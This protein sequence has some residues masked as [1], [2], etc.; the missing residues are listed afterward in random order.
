MASTEWAPK[1]YVPS[2]SVPKPYVPKP[3]NKTSVQP[4]VP[5]KGQATPQERKHLTDF[6][7]LLLGDFLYGTKE[8]QMQLRDSGYEQW[9]F[10]PIMNRIVGA[11]AMLKERQIEPMLKG[12]PMQV[13][14]NTLETYSGTM[15][16]LS[17]PIKSLIP[18]AGGGHSGDFLRS[19]GWKDGEFRK[20]FQFNTGNFIVDMAGEILTDP[21]TYVTA[22]GSSLSKKGAGV[23]AEEGID[24]VRKTLTKELGAE[25]TEQVLS[26]IS[27]NALNALI[28]EYGIDIIKDPDKFLDAM[29]AFLQSRSDEITRL[30]QTAQGNA[31]DTLLKKHGAELENLIK[32]K[33]LLSSTAVK[34]KIAELRFSDGYRYYQMA[35]KLK[36]ADKPLKMAAGILAPTGPITVAF[37]KYI[38]RPLFKHM[39]FNA[40]N[41]LKSFDI[42][43]IMNNPNFV[44]NTITDDVITKYASIGNKFTD[45]VIN[46]NKA[47]SKLYGIITEANI[48]RPGDFEYILD[49]FYKYLSSEFRGINGFD[50]LVDTLMQDELLFLVES[51]KISA[52]I[53]DVFNKVKGIKIAEFAQNPLEIVVLQQS[54]K[55]VVYN[56][57]KQLIQDDF[58]KWRLNEG[59][60]KQMK[61]LE[62]YIQAGELPKEV[63]I[64]SV[65]PLD[66]VLYV[67]DRMFK[68][69]LTKDRFAELMKNEESVRLLNWAG[70][71]DENIVP[72]Q[73][74][75][76]NYFKAETKQAKAKI[77]KEI[78][79]L[80]R[81]AKM[82]YFGTIPKQ[83][84]KSADDV[85]YNPRFQ[86]KN[87]ESALVKLM[88]PGWSAAEGANIRKGIAEATSPDKAKVEKWRFKKVSKAVKEVQDV[89]KQ[90]VEM[91]NSY[92]FEG[93][94]NPVEQLKK[95]NSFTMKHGGNYALDFKDGELVEHVFQSDFFSYLDKL[96]EEIDKILDERLAAG[97]AAVDNLD[98]ARAIIRKEVYTEN[99]DTITGHISEFHKAYSELSYRARSWMAAIKHGNI[100][101]NSILGTDPNVRN[102]ITTL[103]DFMNTAHSAE[104]LDALDEIFTARQTAQAMKLSMTQHF[105]LANSSLALMDDK[106]LEEWFNPDSTMRKSVELIRRQALNNPNEEVRMF[107]MQLS[108]ILAATDS[109]GNFGKLKEY[110][111]EYI[112]SL[113]LNAEA[114]AFLTNLVDDKMIMFSN[115]G[116]YANMFRY[117]GETPTD[118]YMAQVRTLISNRENFRGA[119][120]AVLDGA[121]PRG[122]YTHTIRAMLAQHDEKWL[123]EF[124]KSLDGAKDFLLD[125]STFTYQELMDEL[126]FNIDKLYRTYMKKQRSIVETYGIYN[127]P[128][129]QWIDGNVEKALTELGL[130]FPGVF[131]NLATMNNDV[132]VM[133][134]FVDAMR[135]LVRTDVR[136]FQNTIYNLVTSGDLKVAENASETFLVQEL[137]AAKERGYNVDAVDISSLTRVSTT[138]TDAINNTNYQIGTINN[139]L[140]GTGTKMAKVNVKSDFSDGFQKTIKNVQNYLLVTQA[141]DVIR[142]G[143]IFTNSYEWSV[144][145]GTISFFDVDDFDFIREHKLDIDSLNASKFIG[146]DIN[147]NVRQTADSEYYKFIS[148]FTQAYENQSH[149]LVK[150]LEEVPTDNEWYN[151]LRSM[152]VEVY[153]SPLYGSVAYAPLDPKTYFMNLT[154]RE[155]LAWN[156]I[157]LSHGLHPKM[158]SAYSEMYSE[159]K[160]HLADVKLEKQSTYLTEVQAKVHKTLGILDTSAELQTHLD[161]FGS[162][163]MYYI[164]QAVEEANE[165]MLNTIH[166][167]NLQSMSYMFTN[168]YLARRNSNV[169]TNYMRKDIT[170]ARHVSGIV[171]I[172]NDTR[173]IGELNLTNE[174][175][176]QLSWYGITKDTRLN[177]RIVHNYLQLERAMDVIYSIESWTPEQLATWVQMNDGLFI[178]NFIPTKESSFY[179]KWI[180]QVDELEKLGITMIEF[181]NEAGAKTTNQYLF[182]KTGNQTHNAQITWTRRK[183][184]LPELQDKIT[185]AF[186]NNADIFEDSR[187]PFELWDGNTITNEEFQVIRDALADFEAE[188]YLVTPKGLIRSPYQD[189][190][191]NLERTYLKDGVPRQLSMVLGAQGAYNEL[192]NHP[193]VMRYYDTLHLEAIPKSTSLVKSAI[194]GSYSA[195]NGRNDVNKYLSFFFPRSEFQLDGEFWSEILKDKSD[196]DI[197]KMFGHNQYEAVLLKED[198]KGLPRVYKI[199]ID[200]KRDLEKAIKAG[201]IAVPHDVYRNMVLVVNKRKSDNGFISAW[202]HIVMP[203][204]KTIAI[205]TP[206]MA[207]RNGIDSNIV[208]NAM[209]TDG[210]KGIMKNFEYEYKAAK[211][212]RWYEELY[213]GLVQAAQAR[214]DEIPSFEDVQNLFN[215]LGPG[216][217]TLFQNLSLY[218]NSGASSGLTAPL[219]DA[220]LRKHM[221]EAADEIN[222]ALV[223]Y[224]AII[225]GNPYVKFISGINGFFE[226]TAR[227]GLYLRLVDEGDS[228][229]MALNKVID[230]HFDYG[231]KILGSDAIERLFWFSTFPIN[232][233]A[234]FMNRWMTQDPLLFKVQLNALKLSWN[235]GEN[236]TWD[237]VRNSDYLTYNVGAGNIRFKFNGKDVLLKTGSS[238]LDFLN[239]I[240]DPIGS[241]IERLNPLMTPF[242]KPEELE[243]I[244]PLATPLARLEQIKS[245]RSYIPSLY[246]ILQDFNRPKRHYIEKAPYTYTRSWYGYP[247]KYYPKSYPATPS[248][249][250]Q[251]RKF[252]TRT[253]RYR[254][255]EYM[256]YFGANNHKDSPLFHLDYSK[257]TSYIPRYL[258]YRKSAKN[259]TTQRVTAMVTNQVKRKAI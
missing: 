210:F 96:D 137:R 46:T 77:V 35:S 95:L 50:P 34:N 219:A 114:T 250:K 39:W 143:K 242:I 93:D 116:A 44:L 190:L 146:F 188:G 122:K 170:H 206:G 79:D 152:L 189:T 70:I 12:K 255:W 18:A 139:Y 52:D 207:I 251:L 177:E 175:M 228:I 98:K 30:I 29:E 154:N 88:Q 6:G 124:V 65:S 155:L 211:A 259:Y 33:E 144:A 231:A 1:A 126:E 119:L 243:Q 157:T 195:I 51:G 87:P 127:L 27:E 72:L 134:N 25:A 205:S 71:T 238:M 147:K 186:K 60:T 160:Q 246:T 156:S 5:F 105:N 142:A 135:N 212:M 36:N 75:L 235:D 59:I 67:R 187:I 16:T 20:H 181:S 56:M 171:D 161:K 92:T 153:S 31:A 38:V 172:V 61:N 194:S 183:S 180:E 202:T 131:E 230:T 45:S 78:A 225:S 94:I 163:D 26:N 82:D 254:P 221:R 24:V 84:R 73:T 86:L 8:L 64:N 164:Q 83:L 149:E 241:A 28:R 57:Q 257:V 128:M 168:E 182:I 14:V 49:R 218:Y 81:D 132:F 111:E 108:Y 141:E 233:F 148:F 165:Q 140:R 3:N 253:F 2:F 117:V 256:R 91:M 69:G 204:Y 115:N 121:E 106:F 232:N 197:A 53:V 173:T 22:A 178:Y 125:G 11:Y 40:V 192:L 104:T 249:P 4:K 201:A 224:K 100:D 220:L 19:M 43:T 58:N 179:S 54:L 198:R 62:A 76:R 138:L 191:K 66:R 215:T 237:R 252:Y 184:L 42:E 214:G 123:R 23:L 130:Q 47:I 41:K 209:A 129:V 203:L 103:Y 145:N 151:Y 162:F 167:A 213:E 89:R 32:A 200:N 248:H 245:G 185:T 229:N 120:Q 85:L 55:D 136:Q 222:E 90:L 112:K 158:A 99:L 208:K 196:K 97:K 216:E 239:L 159:F 21:L 17:N 217:R 80:T 236:Y 107:G 223:T 176:H 74:K 48:H 240:F 244:N 101:V 174:Q 15:D 7:D 150:L 10:V 166:A 226:D 68:R 13:L 227:L 199:F 109:H 234:F 113:G 258:S 37:G 193:I 102:F 247:K 133:D 63:N 169:M 9:V 110:A 118:M